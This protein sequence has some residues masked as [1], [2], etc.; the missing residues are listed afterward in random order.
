[1]VK[2]REYAKYLNML[3]LDPKK[4]QKKMKA[5]NDMFMFAYKIKKFQLQ[6]KHPGW[7]DRQLNHAVYALIEKGCR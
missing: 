5:V 6:Q 3:Q 7:T 2:G 4:I 1:M